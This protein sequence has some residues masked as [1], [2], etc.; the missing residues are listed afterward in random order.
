MEDKDKI[1]KHI[2]ATRIWLDKAEDFLEK[3]N[4]I[5]AIANLFLASAEIQLPLRK[6]A[7]VSFESKEEE[8]KTKIISFKR[9]AKGLALAASFI[10]VIWAASV[11]KFNYEQQTA[12]IQTKPK[13]TTQ[14]KK[15]TQVEEK[16]AKINSQ[17]HFESTATANTQKKYEIKK[18]NYGKY[19]NKNKS[20][21]K[22]KYFKNYTFEEKIPKVNK[23]TKQVPIKNLHNTDNNIRN[24]EPQTVK[25]ETTNTKN[26]ISNLEVLDLMHIAEKTLKGKQ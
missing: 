4:V 11:L 22:K 12:K 1:K 14:Q 21:P 7:D 15:T 6:N 23:I 2:S 8:T 17:Q 26:D 10:L 3:N 20:Y 13:V 19:V 24:I 25:T 18:I 16:V 5:K 9:V